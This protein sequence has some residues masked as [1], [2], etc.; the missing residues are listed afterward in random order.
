MTAHLGD[1]DATTELLYPPIEETWR[2]EDLFAQPWQKHGL[3]QKPP[4][5]AEVNVYVA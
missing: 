3:L 2:L 4:K 5:N 1:P